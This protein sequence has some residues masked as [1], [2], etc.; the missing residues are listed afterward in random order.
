MGRP[1]TPLRAS[2]PLLVS[3][4]IA[5]LAVAVPA[6]AHG[7]CPTCVEPAQ[8]SVGDPIDLDYKT[9]KALLNPNRRQ[10]TPGPKPYCYGCQLKLWR[11]RVAG[12]PPVELGVWRPRRAELRLPAP[13]VPPGRYLIA[14]FDGSESGT[15]YTW[16][17]LRVTEPKGDDG[18]ADAPFR[19]LAAVVAVLAATASLV[20]LWRRRARLRS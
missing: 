20:L 18:D 1:R 3:G 10:L 12:V 13:D 15:H 16:D 6:A 14:L 9:Y 5:F 19:L 8:V 17:F 2:L 7:P 4:S 11:Q